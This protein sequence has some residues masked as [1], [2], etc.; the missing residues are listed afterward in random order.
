MTKVVRASPEM[1]KFLAAPDSEPVSGS[2][3]D[4]HGFW[5]LGVV[6]MR[7]LR[8][9]AKAL[10]ICL[11]FLVP[12]IVLGWVY[13]SSTM[14]SI[15]FSAKERLGVEY[16]REIFPVLELAQQLR[17][18]ATNA[19][20]S[21][22]APTTMAD[23]KDKLQAAQT[24]LAEVEKR[25]GGDLDTAK[26]YADV[27]TAFAQANAATA[28][29]AV[30]KAHTAHVDS[31]IA[32][33]NLVTDNSNLTLDPDIASFYVMDAAFAR[34][35]DIIESSAKLRGLGLA[36]LKV[37]SITPAQQKTLS[38]LIPIAEFQSNNMR[39]G[40]A[41]AFVADK[42][43]SD[44]LNVA[45]TLDATTAFFALA[46]KSVIDSQ[47]YAPEVQATYLDAA[48][49]TVH[50]QYE[51]VQR[52]MNELDGLL[53]TRV[54]GMKSTLYIVSA[55]LCVGILLAFYFFYTFYLVTS[56]GLRLISKHLQEMADGDLRRAPAKPWGKDEPAQ[57]IGD[58]R[59]A[60]D[61]LHGLIR[62]VRH[63]ARSLHATSA[64]I[65][66]ASFDLSSRT[67]S[68]A[69]SLEEQS[70]AMEEIG[71]T[72]DNTA[73]LASLAAKFAADNAKVAEAGGKVIATVVTTMQEIY[74]SSSK[75]NDIIG[76][77]NG[78][79][80]QTNILA[81]NAA[82]EAARAGEAGRGFAVVA[83]EVRNLA[84]R[85]AAAAT[86]IKTLISNSV[87]QIASGTKVV[88]QAGTTMTTMV[89]NAK[90][91]N[92]YLSDISSASREQALG[93]T[94]VAAAVH[95]LDEDTQQNAALVEQTTAASGALTQQA[96]T[97]QH[98]I[99]NF[100]VA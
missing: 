4:V 19:A 64:E 16:N 94:Q 44:K 62:T 66:S 31:L 93:V 53:A 69:A 84:Q 85:S 25:L 41:K 43:L 7:N 50:G 14:E 97:L 89:T 95:A 49:K 59:H 42:T 56:G 77:I 79:A 47:D 20:I 24:K 63:S 91:I 98:E 21:G 45:P 2:A 92:V 32:L 18:D 72:V 86:E 12:M 29:D 76:V 57:V 74:T 33:L 78:I 23:V 52:L 80:F 55:I 1:Q 87:D 17:R 71:S 11:M 83:S 70:A 67:E 82:V 8:F 39:T 34:V 26:A 27:Q 99:A 22:T 60:Y 35:P 36:V 90:Q 73:E 6:L 37:G 68:A 54:S 28:T 10:L 40:L 46:R 58:L 51:L 38:E 61:S 65:A 9:K 3:F 96:E 75:I 5:T 48:N 30:F 15:Q 81:L 88:E 100:K 13:Y